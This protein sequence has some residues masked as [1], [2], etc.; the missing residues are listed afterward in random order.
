MHSIWRHISNIID[1]YQGKLPLSHFLKAYFK[2]NPVLGSRDR[3]ILSEMAFCYYRCAHGFEEPYNLQDKVCSA[4]LLTQSKVSAIQKIMP[5]A[6]ANLWAKDTKTITAEL[7]ALGIGFSNKRLLHFDATFSQ[8]IDADLWCASLLSRP[9][10]FIRIMHKSKHQVVQRLREA[11]VHFEQINEHCVAI[12]NATDVEKFLAPETYRI[13]DAS[14][15]ATEEFMKQLPGISCWDCCCGAGG[16]SLLFAELHPQR[17][18]YVSDVRKSILNNLSLRFERYG[19]KKPKRLELSAAD[20][21]ACDKIFGQN[22]FDAI[23]ADVPCSGSG[24]W[25]RT[26]EQYYFFD[27]KE[28]TNFQNKQLAIAKNASR[29]LKTGGTMLYITCS[30]FTAENEQV[31]AALLSEQEEL[32]LES[33]QMING[34]A[35]AADCMFV[36]V[37]KKRKRHY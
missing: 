13:Q 14:S 5:E 10:V 1:T 25:A 19:L 24:T 34:I 7:S 37:F 20:K 22:T 31:I 27:P 6:Y 15:Q 26:P 23:I 36:A 32:E 28:L 9:K 4:L 17:S 33:Q 29:F 18:L 8:G 35:Q 11:Q 30:V 2:K 3:K 21:N 12:D 16:K